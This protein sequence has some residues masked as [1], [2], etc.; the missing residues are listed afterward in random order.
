MLE[1]KEDE[2]IDKYSESVR[3]KRYQMDHKWLLRDICFQNSYSIN[4]VILSY[5]EVYFHVFD[6]C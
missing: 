5:G 6:K 4:T 1:R 2:K 3:E